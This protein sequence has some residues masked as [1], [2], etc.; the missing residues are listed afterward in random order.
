MIRRWNPF[1]VVVAA[2]L[3]LQCIV[4]STAQVDVGDPVFTEECYANIIQAD[5][6][7]NAALSRNEYVTFAQLEA[8]G[9][10]DDVTS[11]PNL[12]PEYRAVFFSLACLCSDADFGGDPESPECCEVP[13]PT[14]RV[15]GPPGDNQSDEDLRM[16]FAICAFTES[17]ARE[18]AGT[19]PP[20]PTAS[21]VSSPVSF[22]TASPTGTPTFGPS[23]SPTTLEPTSAPTLGPTVSPSNS[24]TTLAPTTETASPTVSPTSGPTFAPSSSSVPSAQPSRTPTAKPTISPQPTSSPTTASP[25]ILPTSRP[26]VT[27]LDIPT[28][29]NYTVAFQDG[30]NATDLV[31]YYSDL[32]VSMDQL[33][34]LV[35]SN[36]W[37]QRRLQ[38]DVLI[39]AAKPTS[40]LSSATI[41][42]SGVRLFTSFPSF[43]T[44]VLFM[45]F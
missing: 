24:P 34:D 21:P 32:I 31:P 44:I 13:N 8:P 12:P 45:C 6:D 37:G 26:T 20:S 10:I 42:T 17:A 7:A 16:L 18:V 5:A 30:Q 40:I 27:P 22:P 29:V 25:S 15:P 38:E 4:P 19:D 28:V 1:R 39:R 9:L 43:P 14:I 23:N 3:V 33:A 2:T 35:V 36:I 41:G 11:F